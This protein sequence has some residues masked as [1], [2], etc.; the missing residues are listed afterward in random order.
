MSSL[1]RQQLLEI[2]HARKTAVVAA[3]RRHHSASRNIERL[4]ANYLV[5]DN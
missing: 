3:S 1:P 2:L 5:A 4:P